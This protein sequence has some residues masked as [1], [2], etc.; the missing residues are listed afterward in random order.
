MTIFSLHKFIND[1]KRFK[2]L[3]FKEIMIRSNNAALCFEFGPLEKSF[4]N[5]FWFQSYY[6]S[7][8]NVFS[9]GK[10]L[11]FREQK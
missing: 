1:K 5:L 3:C 11:L 4:D 2:K 7:E 10:N 6:N 9:N 8:K